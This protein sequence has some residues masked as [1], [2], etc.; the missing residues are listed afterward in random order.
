[1]VRKR[2]YKH[3]LDFPGSQAAITCHGFVVFEVMGPP[4]ADRLNAVPVR[5]IHPHEWPGLLGMSANMIY[6]IGD[7]ARA[8]LD[9]AKRT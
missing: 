8:L 7:V 1:M 6:P 4:G 2:A 3:P 5:A 9:D